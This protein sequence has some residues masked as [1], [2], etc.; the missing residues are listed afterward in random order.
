MSARE[1]GAP[2]SHVLCW[3]DG[4]DEACRAAKRAAN[5]AK[6]LGANLSFVAIGKTQG[7]DAG[8]DEYAR[9]ERVSGPMPPLIDPA[10][11]ACLRQAISI[12]KKVGVSDAKQI[13]ISGDPTATICEAAKSIGADLV[14]IGR[15]EASLVTRLLGTSVVDTLADRCQ[16]A[17]L[18]VG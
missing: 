18:S 8:F 16:F 15:H 11:D 17:V 14:V 3:V 4:S 7:Y 12:S 1:E 10:V 2:F 9:L 6:S 13:V 5:L